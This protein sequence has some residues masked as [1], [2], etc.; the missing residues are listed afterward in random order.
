MKGRGADILHLEGELAGAAAARRFPEDGVREGPSPTGF[1]DGARA[2]KTGYTRPAIRSFP[3]T[4]A[5]YRA[6]SASLTND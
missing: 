6:S 5:S 3:A 4:F 2:G 1:S